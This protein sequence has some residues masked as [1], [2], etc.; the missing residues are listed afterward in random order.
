MSQALNR[1]VNCL[2]GQRDVDNAIRTVGEASKTLLSA[3]V[4]ATEPFIHAGDSVGFGLSLRTGTCV[5]GTSGNRSDLDFSSTTLVNDNVALWDVNRLH[6]HHSVCWF[7]SSLRC[8]S[9]LDSHGPLPALVPVQWAE[10]PGGSGSAQ[11]GG[12]RSESV[13]Q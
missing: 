9:L 7:L 8:G 3:S 10:L 6:D 11:R 13:S 2:P 1:T 12:G 5:R 4:S